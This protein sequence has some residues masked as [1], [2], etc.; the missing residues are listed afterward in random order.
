VGYAFSA[1][2]ALRRARRF[3]PGIGSAAAWCAATGFDLTHH[4]PDA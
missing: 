2:T 4:P 1:L 3:R